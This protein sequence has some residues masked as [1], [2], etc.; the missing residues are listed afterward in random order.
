MAMEV[1]PV[2]FCEMRVFKVSLNHWAFDL[3]KVELN[4][5]FEKETEPMDLKLHE[6]QKRCDVQ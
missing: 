3:R 2:D 1:V 4:A 5:I 6:H